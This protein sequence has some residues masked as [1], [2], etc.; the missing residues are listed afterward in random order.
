MLTK[1]KNFL[2]FNRTAEQTLAKNTFWLFFGQISGRLLRAAL[3]IYAA[4]ILG[5]AEWGAFSYALSLVAFILIFS[6]LGIGAIVTRE[7]AKNLGLSEKY[8]S[9]ALFLKI[10]LLAI[11][12]A[13][14]LSF[15]SY[16]SKIEGAKI[17]MPFIALL[18]IFDS[19]RNF[20]FALSRALQKMQIE[21]I[22]EIATNIFIVFFG[23]YVLFTS[24]SGINLTVAYILGA[25]FGLLLIA[26]SFWRYL[27]GLL[28][29]FDYRLIPVILSSSLPFA[30]A[31]FL[32]A[33][34]INTD[35]IMLGWLRTAEEVGFYSVAQKPIQ[36]FYTLAAIFATSLFPALSK[37]TAPENKE[38][39]K[40][41]LEKSLRIS[42]T[43][44]APLAFGGIILSNQ[45]INLLFGESYSPAS[46]AFQ[47][48]LLTLIIIFPSIIISNSLLAYNQ[49]KKF[50]KFSVLGALGNIFFNF[51]LI[52]FWGIAGCA[53]STIFTQL[54]ANAFIWKKMQETNPFSIAGKIKNIVLASAAMII[55]VWLLK[56]FNLPIFIIIPVGAIVYLGGLKLL[57]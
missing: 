17:L 4:R 32:G 57:K 40:N 26:A 45:I 33:I 55:A 48:L 8:F 1:I 2:F 19:L 49:Q 18:L 52:P 37:L 6:D 25:A 20:G 24:P 34:M 7:L 21:A 14:I 38:G 23:F 44:A 28:S 16:L 50:I 54:I 31:S 43:F 56:I 29:H 12:V 47:I 46:T 15:G 13:L 9:T 27:K 3:V 11:C 22:N 42:L 36:L 30:L 41:L 5:P 51:L 10:I 39:F 53:V 35:L